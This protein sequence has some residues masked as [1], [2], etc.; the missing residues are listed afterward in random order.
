MAPDEQLALVGR[1]AFAAV[2]GAF[3][4]LQRELQ[5]YPAGIRTL[6]LVALGSALFTGVSRQLAADDR[7]AAGIVTGIGFLGAGVIFREGY[8][9][10]GITTAATVWAAAAIGMAVAVELYLV[11]GLGTLA[12]VGVLGARPLTRRMD[13]FLRRY[14]GEAES[15]TTDEPA[16]RG[17]PRR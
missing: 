10:K 16:P 3:I 4:G 17:E 13:A 9:V 1:L 14:L 2:L 8:T 15:P 11:S 6:A 12:V 5:G 7:V